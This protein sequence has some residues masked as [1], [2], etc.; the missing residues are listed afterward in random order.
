M[1]PTSLGLGVVSAVLQTYNAVTKAYDV[2]LSVKDFPSTYRELRTAFMVERYRLE[3]WGDQM[4]SEQQ[5]LEQSQHNAAVWKL[6][7]AVFDAMWAAFEE[8][9]KT[10]EA[11][12]HVVGVPDTGDMSDLELLEK[13][14]ISV[15]SPK[16]RSILGLARTIKF[17]LRDKK[18]ME[19]LIKELSY[20]NDSLDKMTSRLEQESA[21]RRLRVKFSTGNIDELHNL[22]AAAALLQH[23]DLEKMASA[24]TVIERGYSDEPPAQ[25]PDG[26][27]LPSETATTAAENDFRLEMNQLAWQGL[28]FMTDQSRAMATYRGEGIIV[29]WRLCRDDTW[30]RQNPR[31]FRQR[32]ENLT[33]VLNSDLRA[34]NVA[35]LHCVGYLDQSST[36]TG[37]AFKIPPEATPGQKPITL[38]QLLTN[39]AMKPSDVPDLGDRFELAKALTT[40][41]FEILN[42]GWLHKNIQPKNVLFWPKKGTR[43]RWDL[44]K[45]YLVGFDISRPNQPGEVSEKPLSDPDD[46]IYRH[47]HYRSSSSSS[48][49]PFLPSFDMYSLGIMLFEIGI[50]RNVGYQG[51]RRPSRPTLETHKSDPNFIEK[52]VMD[53]PVMDLKRH[54]GVKYRDAVTAC[55]SMELDRIWEGKG[56]G[57]VGGKG[58]ERLKFFQGEVQTRVVDA[59]AVCSA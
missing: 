29:D 11:Y 43:D 59:I 56:D 5:Q 3:Q 30:R 4:L 31:A 48:T 10:L 45:P 34:L 44:S 21:R 49:G 6:F 25:P 51:S 36:V 55:L 23:Q 22:R 47:P 19:A 41:V 42:I 7:Q 40:T 54:M 57:G 26:A 33:R 14:Q 50:W 27:T 58:E 12:G 8:S 32:T 2:Y 16:K 35:V 39:P 53:G 20:W 1:D 28:P 52:V 13:L 46:D 38:H 17:V 24:R 9:N 18:K 15:T 37:Y